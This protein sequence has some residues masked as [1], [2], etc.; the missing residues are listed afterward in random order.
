MSKELVLVTGG[1]GFIGS[2]LVDAL[3]KDGYMVRILDNLSEPTHDG[4]MPD[5]INKSAQFMRGDVREKKDW[6]SALKGVSYVFHL[7]AYMDYHFDF[8]KYADTNVRSVALLYEV[9]VQEKLQIQKVII[10]SSQSVYGEGKYE[11]KKHGVFYAEPRPYSQ[12]KKHQWDVRCPLDHTVATLLPELESDELRPQIPYGITKAASEKLCLSLGKTYEI[13][14]VVIRPSIVQG[15]RQSIRSFSGALKDFSIK[16]LSG[17]PIMMY[18]DGRGVRD[19]VN[20]HDMVDAYLLVMK[21]PRA[22]YEIFNVGI[23]ETISLMD[24][25][26]LVFDC[27][28]SKEVPTATGEFRI[29]SPRSSAMNIDKLKKLGWKPTRS[30]TDN[31]VDYVQWVKKY[32]DAILAWKKTYEDMKKDG[33]LKK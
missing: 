33:I 11:C 31:I 25:A 22:N 20:V 17:K 4:T 30:L 6:I 7:A 8:S 12:L 24:F 2:H 14:S 10:A 27:T 26:Q 19:F 15:S 32:P 3:I 29:N 1:A 28:N 18:E 13:P 5:W 21:D 9:I 16:A 23:G